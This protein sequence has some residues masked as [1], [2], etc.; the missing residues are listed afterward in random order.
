MKPTILTEINRQREIMGLSSLQ[1]QTTWSS[2]RKFSAWLAQQQTN[3]LTVFQQMF[4]SAPRQ[5]VGGGMKVEKFLRKL[6]GKLGRALASTLKFGNT[7][8]KPIKIN[9]TGNQAIMVTDK[10]GTSWAKARPR[11][12]WSIM[13]QFNK[14]NLANFDSEQITGIAQQRGRESVN[15]P[16]FTKLTKRKSGFYAW[17]AQETTFDYSSDPGQDEIAAID[18]TIITVAGEPIHIDMT[19]AFNNLEVIANPDEI[20]KAKAELDAAE[21]LGTI[22][23]IKI[24]STA[25][26]TGVDTSK[27]GDDTFYAQMRTANFPQYLNITNFAP[28]TE[29]GEFAE[30][31]VTSAD[32]ALAVV[33]GKYLARELGFEDTQVDYVFSLVDPTTGTKEVTLDVIGQG[34]DKDEIIDPG[35]KGQAYKGA[36]GSEE[37][38]TAGLSDTVERIHVSIV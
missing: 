7:T 22:E 9:L 30:T 38:S 26:A 25:T 37:S 19:D 33:R 21:K 27:G 3:V 18:P 12:L 24:S 1:E 15:I 17:S 29:I 11:D 10:F 16:V 2:D 31:E 36:S 14:Y 35:T 23:R 34:K 4:A 32:R 20:T 5:N 6:A 13:L 28:D 8:S